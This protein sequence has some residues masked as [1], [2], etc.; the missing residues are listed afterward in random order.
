[1]ALPD[2]ATVDTPAWAISDELLHRAAATVSEELLRELALKV[3][4]FIRIGESPPVKN[5]RPT[6]WLAD[7]VEKLGWDETLSK[8]PE[9]KAVLGRLRETVEIVIAGIEAA[10]KA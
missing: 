4:P 7:V 5:V 6:G 9:A 1:M 8:H 10:S 3:N 2:A